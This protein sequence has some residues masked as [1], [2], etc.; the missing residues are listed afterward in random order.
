LKDLELIANLKL[1][2]VLSLAIDVKAKNAG[3]IARK[4]TTYIF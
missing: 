4:E 2:F 3:S 1:W